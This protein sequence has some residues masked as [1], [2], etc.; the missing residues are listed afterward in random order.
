MNIL[1]NITE[2]GM[3]ALGLSVG[4]IVVIWFLYSYYSKEGFV[5]MISD[6]E[7][8]ES[9]VQE[10]KYDIQN[11]DQTN[12]DENMEDAVEITQDAMEQA[13]QVPDN[14]KHLDLLP[15][16]ELAD[17]F[18]M[19]QPSVPGELSQRNYL[20]APFLNGTDTQNGTLKNANRSIRSDPVIPRQIVSVWNNSTYQRDEYR[21]DF[22]IGQ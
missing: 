21:K 16:D 9:G 8:I 3:I 5:D 11:A 12:A 17:Q 19:G 18:A 13:E 22:E 1:K 6:I 4:L 14:L 20:E 10:S 15:N 7:K 2:N